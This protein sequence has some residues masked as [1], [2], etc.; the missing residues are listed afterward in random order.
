[1]KFGRHSKTINYE[2]II[3]YEIILVMLPASNIL[4]NGLGMVLVFFFGM[5]SG[6]EMFLLKF[7]ILSYFC[8]QLI[9]R[10][11]FLRY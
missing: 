4:H 11:V 1:M 9:R 3:S 10:L 7:F 2:I 6:L 5:I 8:A